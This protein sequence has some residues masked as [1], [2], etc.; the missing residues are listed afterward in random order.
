MQCAAQ[1][2]NLPTAGG[3][4]GRVI[5]VTTLADNGPGSLR[6]A[7]EAEGPRRVVFDVAGEIWPQS[8]LLIRS[9]H[10][11]VDGGTAPSPGISIMGQR[12]RIRTHDVI[13]RHLRL[14]IGARADGF[15]PQNRDAL[16]IDGG[17]SA[18]D[19]SYNVLIENCSF[20]WA[21]DENVQIW[22]RFNRNIVIRRSIIAE[23]LNRSI[24]PKGPHSMGMIVGPGIQD[25][26][27]SENIFAHNALRNPVISG[28]A[29]AAIINNL[30]YGAQFNAFHL[31]PHR[32]GGPSRITLAGNLV[33]AGPT[34]RPRLPAFGQG[35]N[36]GTAVYFSGNRA[37]GTLA[38][39]PDELSART[40]TATSP[41]V[42]A[43]PIALPPG[44]VIPVDH[45]EEHLFAVAGARPG[46]RDPIDRRI[47]L[48]IRNRTGGLKDEPDD[49]RLRT[50]EP[51]R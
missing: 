10:L 45:L 28:G 18:E 33:I 43:P 16:A 36:E 48:E 30:V 19:A 23:A 24:H 40:P 37:I 34:T 5:R 9:P 22:G 7:L 25:V 8:T 39:E 47:L 4:S 6:A 2:A 27:I 20:A 26:V 1:A 51:A 50:G 11:T 35:F 31:Y 14:R 15:D 12:I 13:L 3:N 17:N 49:P 32:E 41:R 44:P 46:D 42:M 29:S 38:L 21:V